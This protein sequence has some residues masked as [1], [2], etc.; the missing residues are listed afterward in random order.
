M[1]PLV[2]GLAHGVLDG[3]EEGVRHRAELHLQ[4]E[5]D[6]RAGRC[7]VDAQAD[8]REE[9]VLV[10]LDELRGLPGADDPFDAQ[11]CGLAE[12]DVEAVLVGE[13]GLEDLLLH[14]AVEGDGGLL[15]AF[16]VAQAD[17]RVLFGEPGEREVERSPVHL[18]AGDDDGLQGRR[19]EDLLVA[20]AGRAE[21]V[22]DPDVAEAGEAGDLAGDDGVRGGVRA[23]GED[24]DPGDP[25]FGAVRSAGD[26]VAGAQGAGEHPGVGG[27]LPRRAPFDLEHGRGDRPVRVPVG[28]RQ[29]CLDAGQERVDTGARGGGAEVDRVDQGLTGLRNEGSVQQGVRDGVLDVRGQQ[30]VVVVG[31][32]VQRGG[33]SGPGDEAGRARAEAGGGPHGHDRGGQPG[34]D[35]PQHL[36][37]TRP[38]P[39][40][41]VDEEQGR[42]AQPPQRPHQHPRLGLH[43][44]DGGDHED[45]PVQHAEHALHLGDEVRVTGRID[46]VDGHTVE[47]ERDDGGLDGDA[48]LP[49]QCEGVGAGAA[50]VDAADLVD[51]PGRMEQ[52]LGQAGLTRVDMGEDSKVEHVHEASCPSERGLF[53]PGGT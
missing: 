27:L 31:E 15:P 47:R 46:E 23:V 19:G 52:P 17:Q 38:A 3:L 39:V 8:R 7:G 18:R 37:V 14:L 34:R 43:P 35:A 9:R 30:G 28:R 32:D 24:A 42:D 44:L 10:L 50:V 12:G 40:D 49:L 29:Q 22:A 25:A 13:G 1:Q 53:L 45:D 33:G 48:A 2:E 51:H 20:L 11:R 21:R 36:P 5:R 16:V 41:L 4:P 26:P 6:A